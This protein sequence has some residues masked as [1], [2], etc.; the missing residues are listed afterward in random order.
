ML[1]VTIILEKLQKLGSG[2]NLLVWICEFLIGWAMC[3]K[4]AGSMSSVKGISGGV[5]QGTVLGVV[6]YLIYVNHIASS[7][8]C[9]RRAFANDFKLY[10]SF[11]RSSF[12][13]ML[14]G[15]MS[16]QSDLS[17]GRE[18]AKSWNLRLNIGK[19]VVMRFGAHQA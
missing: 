1:L 4:I 2:G 15:M 12:I 14:Q 5:P 13:P 18:I 11:P 3:V 17:K 10:L 19:C 16:L 9:C 7:V 8:D 6:L